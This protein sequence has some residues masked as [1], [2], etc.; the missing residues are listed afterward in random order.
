MSAS[1]TAD[2]C[3]RN[4]RVVAGREFVNWAKGGGITNVLHNTVDRQIF[5]LH[6][7]GGGDGGG[8]DRN[9]RAGQR[10]GL[11]PLHV[12]SAGFDVSGAGE[13]A[14][15]L[16]RIADRGYTADGQLRYPNLVVDI[17]ANDGV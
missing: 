3:T 1:S 10:A 12:V 9:T 8:G 15:L 5:I 16:R 14:F 6:N 2:V 17:G 11:V 13:A 4:L 7:G